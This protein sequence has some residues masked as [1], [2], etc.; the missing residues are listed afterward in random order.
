MVIR[1]VSYL[2]YSLEGKLFTFPND[3]ETDAPSNSNMNI[4]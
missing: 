1:K 2:S 3:R 4:Y